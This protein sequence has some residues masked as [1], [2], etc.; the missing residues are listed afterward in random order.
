MIA[1]LTTQQDAETTFTAARERVRELTDALADLPAAYQTA[2]KHGDTT[3]AKA[4]RV[5]RI[6]LEEE[7]VVARI[8][9]VRAEVALIEA[10]LAAFAGHEQDAGLA[11]Q[12]TYAATTAAKATLEAAIRASNNAQNDAAMVRAQRED[13][14]FRLAEARK[15]LQT[16]T[17]VTLPE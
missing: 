16:L 8:L 12:T 10:E 6:D 2:V 9:A 5:Q 3:A 15:R 11:V 4:I 17:A 14:A 1:E 7:I 13:V